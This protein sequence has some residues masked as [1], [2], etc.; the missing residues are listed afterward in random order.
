M[1]EPGG[2]GADGALGVTRTLVGECSQSV[3]S[4]KVSCVFVCGKHRAGGR[5]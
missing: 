2:G 5:M 1:K 3:W 4:L